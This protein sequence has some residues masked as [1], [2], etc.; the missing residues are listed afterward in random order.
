MGGGRD[1][2][3]GV[4]AAHGIFKI[5]PIGWQPSVPTSPR[6]TM[7]VRTNTPDLGQQW[8]CRGRGEE[9]PRHWGQG[10][11]EG[12]SG[13]HGG[14]LCCPGPGREGG[15]G[16]AENWSDWSN[17]PMIIMMVSEKPVRGLGLA[18]KVSSTQP[19]QW[20]VR[21]STPTPT[22]SSPSS[23]SI[24]PPQKQ[25]HRP[26]ANPGAH[27]GIELSRKPLRQLRVQSDRTRHHRP[28]RRRP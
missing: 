20:T 2:L 1:S 9:S 10:N 19:P 7:E 18:G 4:L 8:R 26:K 6:H 14:F 24:K 27:H 22:S 3:V 15:G 28:R 12:G 23:V 25:T 16:V 17:W 13:K 11:S 21:R 5:G